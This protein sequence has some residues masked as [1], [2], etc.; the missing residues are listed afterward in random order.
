MSAAA[1]PLLTCSVWFD[2]A[3]PSGKAPRERDARTKGA[4]E[5]HSSF[6]RRVVVLNGSNLVINDVGDT[7]AADGQPARLPA[8]PE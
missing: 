2:G 4:G 3:D 7:G 8:A 6:H 5:H 1:A